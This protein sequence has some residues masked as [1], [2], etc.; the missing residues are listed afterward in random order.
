MQFKK[1][2]ISLFFIILSA[3]NL[4]SQNLIVYD[5]T[6]GESYLVKYYYNPNQNQT[7]TNY[8]IQEIAKSIPKML[9]YTQYVYAYNQHSRIIKQSSNNYNV[10][11]EL[12]DANCTGDINFKGFS[13]NDVLLP[14][15]ISYNLM[16]FNGNNQLIN[17]YEFKQVPV[18][19]IN[20]R[21]SDFEFTDTI[22]NQITVNNTYYLVIENKVF[23]YNANAIN[24]FN[25]KRNLIEDYY[26]TDQ[27]IASSL[28]TLQGID[29][30]NLEMINLFDIKVDEIEQELSKI[31]NKE[32]AQKLKL[33]IYD[34]IK[35]LSKIESLSQQVY[36]LRFN[37]NQILASLDKMY[38]E[39]GLS[40]LKSGAVDKAI[41][42]FNKSI[43]INYYYCPAHYQLALI[44]YN[45]GKLD[46]AAVIIKEV[47]SKMYPD[48]TTQV[49]VKEMVQSINEAYLYEG[50]KMIKSED[51]NEALVFLEKGKVFCSSTP[52]ITCNEQLYSSIATAK[53]GIFSSYLSVADKAVENSKFEL[54]EIYINL[55][56]KYQKENKADIINSGDIDIVLNKLMAKYIENGFVS[57]DAKKFEQALTYFNKTIE[58]QKL[59]Q[60]TAS[61]PRLNEGLKTAKNGIYQ[62][63]IAKATDCYLKTDYDNAEGI[64]N[65]A[66]L[67]Q[68]NNS[69]EIANSNEAELLLAKIK[70]ERYLI[71][72]KEGK[73]YLLVSSYENA[74]NKFEKARQ[75]ENNYNF[76]K[77]KNLDSLMQAAIKPI[78]LKN[79]EKG[80]F[81][82]F[83]GELSVAK[84]IITLVLSQQIKYNLGNDFD[85]NTNLKILKD[86]IFTEECNNAQQEY[87]RNYNL[88]QQKITEKLF[89]E[90]EEYLEAAINITVVNAVCGISANSADNQKF[91]ILPAVNYQ[92]LLKNNEEAFKNNN[93]GL[94]IDKHIE[95]EKYYYQFQ[96]DKFGLQHR[97]L[98]DYAIS[99]NKVNFFTYLIDYYTTKNNCNDAF[100]LLKE[101]KTRN[102]PVKN[103]KLIQENLALQMAMNDF[104][105]NPK[106]NPKIALLAYTNGD[107]WFKYFSKAYLKKR[108]SIK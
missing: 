22:A 39:R 6:I 27:L 15:F 47:L 101:L 57:N 90:A 32:F 44:D 4:N 97:S 80:N 78:I 62:N 64:T 9:N 96:L 7:I 108:K 76:I 82:V 61:F 55:A 11:V 75:L 2:L 65:Q 8:Y 35:F 40:L 13:M 18:G 56:V 99:K 36:S 77:A 1:K 43:E 29:L 49:L 51:F 14:A 69:N 46:E 23:S 3:Y 107:K 54:A 98:F 74:V 68:T 95:A 89:I 5:N 28:S 19:D 63:F 41:Y 73:D 93:F 24:S 105:Q 16:V 10:I 92:K 52:G 102:Y 31:Y 72:I 103:T 12:N 48:Y 25:V 106:S 100:A 37:I 66:I 42:N 84:E 104:K 59:L 21:I 70:Y 53:Y 38:Y 50:N 45:T 87:D 67:F 85:I 91:I 20:S 79:I 26:L 58:L 30:Q 83:N 33:N 71:L 94:V 86:K 88:A 60:T 81:K 17:K 34:P